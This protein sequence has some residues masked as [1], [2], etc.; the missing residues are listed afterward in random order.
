MTSIENIIPKQFISI[1]KEHILNITLIED[2]AYFAI[3]LLNSKE[4][5]TFLLLLKKVFEY[6]KNNNVKYV[7]QQINYED[8]ELFKKSSFVEENNILIVKT[9]ID[10]FIYELCDALGMNR[11]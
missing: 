10:I 5:K 2:T 3:E 6:M 7:K 8:K 1:D 11:L 9:D 4:Y